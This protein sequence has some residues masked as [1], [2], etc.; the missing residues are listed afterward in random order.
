MAKTILSVITSLFKHPT[1]KA[2]STVAYRIYGYS[3]RHKKYHL[4]NAT[5]KDFGGSK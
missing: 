1:Y 2:P 3:I 5:P 4:L